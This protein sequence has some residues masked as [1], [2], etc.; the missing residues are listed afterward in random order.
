MYTANSW[1]TTQHCTEASIV[2]HLRWGHYHVALHVTCDVV[3]VTPS[4]LCTHA[5]TQNNCA[6]IFNQTA[7]AWVII[8]CR[9]MS[10]I[11][12]DA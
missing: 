6:S 2:G 5:Q 7:E 11:F 4:R 3:H 1:Q 10:T 12:E 9:L 8:S